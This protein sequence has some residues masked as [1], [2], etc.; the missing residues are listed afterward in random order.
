MEKDFSRREDEGCLVEK[1]KEGK[2]TIS[3]S[4]R[5]RLRMYR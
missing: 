5:G 1:D 3:P 2:V 4:L